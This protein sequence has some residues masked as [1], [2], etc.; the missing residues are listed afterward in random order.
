RSASA[1]RAYAIEI[2]AWIDA[3]ALHVALEMSQRLH[4]AEAAHAFAGAWR[5]ALDALAT[6]D[7][8]PFAGRPLAQADLATIGDLLA[9]LDEE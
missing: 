5:A 1:P 4:G 3:G 7:P 8:D 6:F 2:N 9:E